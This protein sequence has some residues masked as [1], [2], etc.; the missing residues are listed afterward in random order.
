MLYGLLSDRAGPGP[1]PPRRESRALSLRRYV[2]SN[3]ETPNVHQSHPSTSKERSL[4]S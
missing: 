4:A 3:G 1:F 2:Y